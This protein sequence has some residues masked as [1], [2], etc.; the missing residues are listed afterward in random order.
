MISNHSGSGG[1]GYDRIPYMIA[2]QEKAAY[3]DA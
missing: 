1:P 2:F 3:K